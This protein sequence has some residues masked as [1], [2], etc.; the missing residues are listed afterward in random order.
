MGGEIGMKPIIL[1]DWLGIIGG[2]NIEE[3]EI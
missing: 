2:V 1:K 3:V